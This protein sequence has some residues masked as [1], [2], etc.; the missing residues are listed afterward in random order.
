MNQADAPAVLRL[1]L[2]TN[3]VIHAV[4]GHPF[5]AD[6]EDLVSLCQQGDAELW[7][8][9]AWDQDQEHAGDERRAAN[10]RW[11]SERPILG[12]VPQPLLLDYGAPLGRVA[13]ADERTAA[14]GQVIQEILLPPDL[15]PGAFDTS[16][17]HLMAR[18]RK[19]ARDVQHL[20]SHVL[21][22][23][24]LFVTS[25]GDDMV[26]KRDAL[27]RRVGIVIETP[28]EAA[29]RIRDRIPMAQSAE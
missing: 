12:W 13:L 10:L 21:H 19:R 20:T 5:G 24:D 23:H 3:C 11:I 18:W 29:Q 15:R 4:A 16:D 14:A 28:A 7:L 1:T 25:D 6:V 9:T 2:D 26:T 17:P 22:R 27:L 8:T